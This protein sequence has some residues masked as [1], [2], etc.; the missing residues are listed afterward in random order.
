MLIFGLKL[1]RLCSLLVPQHTGLSLR[2]QVARY[3]GVG[4]EQLGRSFGSN[5][6]KFPTK[7]AGGCAYSR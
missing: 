3:M 1:L 7:V 5:Y 2:L 6:L 4:I